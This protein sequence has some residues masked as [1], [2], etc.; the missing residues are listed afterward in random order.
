MTSETAQQVVEPKESGS[1][2]A[3]RQP[4]GVFGVLAVVEFGLEHTTIEGSQ[5]HLPMS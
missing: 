5:P 3:D 2:C 4:L 1:R